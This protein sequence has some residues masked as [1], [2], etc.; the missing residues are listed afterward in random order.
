MNRVTVV[1][2]IIFLCIGVGFYFLF[3]DKSVFF[4]VGGE[5]KKNIDCSLKTGLDNDICRFLVFDYPFTRDNISKI[6]I[7]SRRPGVTIDGLGV[8]S[9]SRVEGLLLGYK[10]LGDH[11]LMIIGFDDN[12]KNRFVIPVDIPMYAVKD[13]SNK[14]YFFAKKINLRDMGKYIGDLKIKDENNLV[15]LLDSLKQQVIVLN[16]MD[17]TVSDKTKENLGESDSVVDLV[18]S[19]NNRINQ[20][21][22]LISRIYNNG[23]APQYSDYIFPNISVLNIS[24]I[25]E[26]NVNEIPIVTSIFF[27][28]DN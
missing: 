9:F 2:I 17:K 4:N 12:N 10:N 1:L 6:A 18:N 11:L 24:D 21:R 19:I 25:N 22:G 23:F 14:V 13:N 3:F 27:S 5:S 28:S 7:K 8:E 26:I 20:T 15:A 16:L